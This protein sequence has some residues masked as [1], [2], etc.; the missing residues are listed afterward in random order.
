MGW[1]AVL[2]CVT[3]LASPVQAGKTTKVEGILEYRKPGFI[4]VDGQRVQPSP[5]MKFKGSGSVKKYDAI[6]AGWEIRAE[7]SR[8]PDGTILVTKMDARPNGSAMFEGEVL[9]ATNAAEKQYVSS[10]KIADQGPDGKEQVLGELKTTGPE[11]DRVRK[12]VDRVA[13]P[14]IDRKSIRVYVV[15]NKEWNAMAMANYS[16]YTFTG[17]MKDL[18]DDELAIV[19]GHEIAHAN[20]GAQ[21]EAGEEGPVQPGRRLGRGTGSVPDRQRHREGCRRSGGGAQFVRVQQLVQP[22]LR[23]PGGPGWSPVRVRGGLRLHQGPKLWR[24]FA[25]KYGDSNEIE[26]F[27]FGNHSLSMKRADALDRE[28]KNNYSNPKLDPPTKTATAPPAA[29]A[30]TTKK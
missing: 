8:Q 10:G 1:V 27:F 23:G 14:Y 13:P 4:V 22:R 20:P 2:G 26:N 29:K 25:E 21:P 9:Q 28:I 12:I 30:T 15:E 3:C 24:R 6:P 7:G 11:V 19:L 17:I 16:I 5:K 18:D